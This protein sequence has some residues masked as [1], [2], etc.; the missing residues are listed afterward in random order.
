[1]FGFLLSLSATSCTH[2]MSARESVRD[3]SGVITTSVAGAH[4]ARP[5]PANSPKG[6]GLVD[7]LIA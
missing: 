2:P 6:V 3:A 7:I 4:R 1:M 5:T